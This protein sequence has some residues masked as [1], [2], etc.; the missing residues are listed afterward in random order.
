MILFSIS[1]FS[2]HIMSNNLFFV[3]Y[4]FKFGPQDY[5]VTTNGESNTVRKEDEHFVTCRRLHLFAGGRP[6]DAVTTVATLP[7]NEPEPVESSLSP[8]AVTT[9]P[10]ESEPI[11][12]PYA[13]AFAAAL[14][15]FRSNEQVK[16]A[17]A[18]A[19][20]PPSVDPI[21]PGM[22]FAEV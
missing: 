3:S 12:S 8:Y 1:P 6:A 13:V 9:V 22:T 21:D 15:A 11:S 5:N 19:N 14:T 17:V 18:A 4:L 20:Y 2:S 10:N 16:P 7:H